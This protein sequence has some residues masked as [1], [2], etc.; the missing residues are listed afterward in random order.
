MSY[1]HETNLLRWNNI[2]KQ[3]RQFILD[4]KNTRSFTEDI[5][6]IT[7]SM[8]YLKINRF[9]TTS[10]SAFYWD[11]RFVWNFFNFT[12]L[13]IEFASFWFSD[14]FILKRSIIQLTITFW[15]KSTKHSYNEILTKLFGIF[16]M[17]I[18]FLFFRE[19]IYWTQEKQIEI[20]SL[21][22]TCYAWI[23][24]SKISI[25][26]FSNFETYKC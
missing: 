3:I 26:L 13:P 16:Q 14:Y 24:S 15:Q 21:F 4:F 19:L 20:L 7:I 23:L 10:K 25:F 11:Y 6:W 1:K 18:M 8:F 5:K 12:I 22:I 17:N 2:L 9:L